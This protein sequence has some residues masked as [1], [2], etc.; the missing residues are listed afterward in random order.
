MSTLRLFVAVFLAEIFL[1]G[2]ALAAVGSWNGVAFTAWNGVAQTSWNGTGIS[3]AGGGGGPTLVASDNFDAYTSGVVLADQ[4]GW[5]AL[6]A[7]TALIYN[8]SG[9]GSVY[10]GSQGMARNTATFNADQRSVCTLQAM[11]G[12]SFKFVCV[13]VRCQAGADTR[14]WF[15]TDGTNWYLVVRIA[16]SQTVITSGTHSVASGDRIALNATGAGSATRLTAQVYTG[17]SWSNV[18]GAV[19]VDPGAG[20]YIDGGAAGVGGDSSDTAGAQGDD[21][22][23]WNL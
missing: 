1:V 10:A 16:A 14:Y 12:G 6:S 5:G 20:L 19:S 18:T 13:G 22:E 23:G 15:Q 3:C 7:S 4:A 17:G 2:P 9:D 21:W 8:P 11:T